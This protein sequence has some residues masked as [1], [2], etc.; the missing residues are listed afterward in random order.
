MGTASIKQGVWGD[1][2]QPSPT[3]GTARSPGGGPFPARPLPPRSPSSAE[4]SQAAAGSPTPGCAGRGPNQAPLHPAKA[5]PSPEARVLDTT[6]GFPASTASLAP[7]WCWGSL[8]LSQPRSSPRQGS[9][10]AASTRAECRSPVLLAQDKVQGRCS[11]AGP[12]TLPWGLPG[13]ALLLYDLQHS[14]GAWTGIRIPS[15]PVTVHLSSAKHHPVL[16]TV[17]ACNLSTV[18]PKPLPQG[19][20]RDEMSDTPLPASWSKTNERARRGQADII[21]AHAALRAGRPLPVLLPRA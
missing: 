10:L 5:C 4:P 16:P 1:F 17:D 13:I 9:S 14:G 20:P 15:L 2:D 11:A 12:S 7:L 6:S 3:P 18:T 19:T 21:V 8:G